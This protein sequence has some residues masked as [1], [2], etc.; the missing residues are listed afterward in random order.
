[1][2]PG[3]IYSTAEKQ[4]ARALN[5]LLKPALR[6]SGVSD[7]FGDEL[8]KAFTA[9]FRLED[10]LLMEIRPNPDNEFT[11]VGFPRRRWR[12]LLLFEQQFCDVRFDNFAKFLINFCLVLA[13]A[14]AKKEARAAPNEALVFIGPFD[15]F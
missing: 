8:V 6:T 7:G 9:R 5:I 3:G 12:Q 10:G 14:S 15:D 2:K 11:A 4:T 1:M 13:V